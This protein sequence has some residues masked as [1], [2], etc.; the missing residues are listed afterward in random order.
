MLNTCNKI[1]ALI[2]LMMEKIVAYLWLLLEVGER[3]KLEKEAEKQRFHY[4]LEE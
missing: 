1:A 3:T 2:W 4:L